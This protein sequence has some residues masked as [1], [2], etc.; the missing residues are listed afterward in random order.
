MASLKDA[1]SAQVPRNGGP[2]CQVCEMVKGL[3][4]ADAA[5]LAEA[6]TD[7]RVSATMIVKALDEIGQPVS[8]GTMRRHRRKECAT[9]RNVGS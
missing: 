7:L 8:V 5:A 2:A 4:K 1:L 3:D 9:L 6:M